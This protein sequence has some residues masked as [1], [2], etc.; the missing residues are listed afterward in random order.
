MNRLSLGEIEFDHPGWAETMARLRYV[1]M[2][3]V[4]NGLMIDYG[5][6][7]RF[8]QIMHGEL[9]FMELTISGSTDNSGATTVTVEPRTPLVPGQRIPIISQRGQ[10]EVAMRTAE[11]LDTRGRTMVSREGYESRV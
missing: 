2:Y 11:W 1:V 9:G 10:D 5:W 8:L 6:L 7:S 4:E 3:R